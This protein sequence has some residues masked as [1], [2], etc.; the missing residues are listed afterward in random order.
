M[1]DLS[2]AGPRF[3]AR[4]NVQSVAQL[5]ASEKSFMACPTDHLM[6]TSSKQVVAVCPRKTQ[7]VCVENVAGKGSTLT[8][9]RI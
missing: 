9:S 7:L 6:M 8:T 4:S 5:V 3:K 2:G 1:G